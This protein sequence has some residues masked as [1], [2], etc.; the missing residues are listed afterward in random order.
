MYTPLRPCSIVDL[1]I[2]SLS[3][4][5]RTWGQPQAGVAP[6]VLVHGWMDVGA[7]YQF[8]VD[9]LSEAFY[10]GRH[11]IA[12]DWRGF[13]HSRLPAPCDHYSFADYLGDLDALLDHYVPEGQTIDLVGHSMGGNVAMLYAGA[14]PARIRKLIN[15]EGFGL[16]ASK[17]TH[18]PKRMGQWLDELKQLRQGEISLKG[19]D[20]V[21]AVAQRLRKT[22]PRLSEDK[23][24]WLAHEWSAPDASGQWRILGDAAHKVV[25]PQ[26]FRVDEALAMYA[27]ITA[28]VLA[29]EARE[30]S[31]SQWWQGKYSLGEYHE[32]LQSVPNCR[33]EQIDDA[34]HMLHHDQPQ[35]I[36]ELI[37]QFC[38]E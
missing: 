1:P 7:S 33:V 13:G 31:M 37:E 21:Q 35:R 24:L 20:S 19:Y 14:R 28:P 2:R 9:A 5:V 11:I 30:D 36:A 3:Y 27:A 10:A 38:A 15:L 22:N 29:I 16:P 4:R 6:L 12:P 26:L 34:G 32:R 17:P 18:A 25:N 23:A 8:V